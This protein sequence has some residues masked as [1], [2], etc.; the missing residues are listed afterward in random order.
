MTIL[1]ACQWTILAITDGYKLGWIEI[2]IEQ[3][4]TQEIQRALGAQIKVGR[5]LA[6]GDRYIIRVTRYDNIIAR[7]C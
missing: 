1:I 2:W 7:N 4:D 6:V 5:E 3:Q